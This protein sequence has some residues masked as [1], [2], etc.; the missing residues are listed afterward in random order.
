MGEKIDIQTASDTTEI[1]TK[2]YDSKGI[3]INWI[4]NDCRF[5]RFII[6]D[7]HHYYTMPYAK[8]AISLLH[9]WYS[10]FRSYF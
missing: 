4:E 5:Q 3:K 2:V 8:Q 10:K 6:F 9:D 7:K 1:R